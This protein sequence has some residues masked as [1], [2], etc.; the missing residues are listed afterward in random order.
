MKQYLFVY[1][2]AANRYR[3]TGVFHRVQKLAK[4]QL[5]NAAFYVAETKG[6]I[7]NIVKERAQEFDVIVAC[8]GDG[9]IRETAIALLEQE[10]LLGIIPMGSGNDLCKSLGIPSDLDKSIALLKNGTSTKVD[11]GYCNNIY[12]LNTLGFGF[13]GLTNKF[14]SE[15]SLKNGFL[16]YAFGALKANFNRTVFSAEIVFPNGDKILKPI[17]MLTAANGRVEGGNFCVAPKASMLDGKLDLVIL[18]PVSKW[19]LPFKLPLFLNGSHLKLKEVQTIQSA[20]C[21]ISFDMPVDIH[22]DGEVIESNEREFK[23][24]VKPGRLAVISRLDQ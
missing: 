22:A 21:N 20:E 9:T 4:K 10:A 11:I 17:M 23:V 16:R 3:S 6:A 7:S 8:G 1:N 13:D 5:D 19:L 18:E 14:A 15:S 12:F 2:P 24:G